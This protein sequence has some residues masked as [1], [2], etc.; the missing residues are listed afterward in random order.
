MARHR[1]AKRAAQARRSVPAK[2]DARKPARRPP[3]AAR[4]GRRRCQ[5]HRPLFLADGQRQE[6]HDHAGGVWA[7][8]RDPPGRYRQGRP[9]QARTFSRSHRTTACPPSSIP[10]VPTARPISRSSGQVAILQ[11]LG[12]KAGKFLSRRT[13][14]AAC[15]SISGCSGRSGGSVRWAGRPIISATTRRSRS[16]TPSSAIL[17]RDRT[18]AVSARWTSSWAA[19]RSWPASIPSPT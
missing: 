4:Q 3:A 17:R 19:S 1:K 6:D 14:A 7:A 12:R 13:S 15:G 5:A 18:A 8:L 11:Y 9:V 10:T 16:T 2:S